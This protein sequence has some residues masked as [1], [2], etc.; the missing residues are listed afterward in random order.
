M[1][2]IITIVENTGPFSHTYHIT[3][4]EKGTFFMCVLLTE[5]VPTFAPSQPAHDVPEISPEG[6]P[7][8]PNVWDL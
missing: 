6:S 7:K 8:G 2:L 4:S 3:I 5:N 1:T